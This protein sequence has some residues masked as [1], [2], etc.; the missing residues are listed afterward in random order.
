MAPRAA[1]EQ[2]QQD[3]KEAERQVSGD[4]PR[5]LPAP[6]PVAQSD[7]LDTTPAAERERA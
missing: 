6:E 3:V 4:G 7:L 1:A 5:S 2:V